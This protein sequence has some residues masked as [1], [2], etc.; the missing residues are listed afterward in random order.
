MK[1]P[2]SEVGGEGRSQKLVSGHGTRLCVHELEI[3]KATE[4]MTKSGMEEVL[5]IE[6]RVQ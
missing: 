6:S 3:S 1:T 2:A 4:L 5:K